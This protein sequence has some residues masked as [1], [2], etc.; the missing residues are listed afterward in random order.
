MGASAEVYPQP[1]VDIWFGYQIPC[2]FC[3]TERFRKKEKRHLKELREKR[4][5]PGSFWFT[6]VGGSYFQ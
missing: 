4:P 6:A 2:V 3:S 1:T 5:N